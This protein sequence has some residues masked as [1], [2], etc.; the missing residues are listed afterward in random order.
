MRK[1]ILLL[2][3]FSLVCCLSLSILSLNVHAAPRFDLNENDELKQLRLFHI[4]LKDEKT[5]KTYSEQLRSLPEGI[6]FQ[7]FKE[8]AKVFSMDPGSA[9]SGGD[10]AWV[11]AG[12]FDEKFEA[13][14]F[15]LPLHEV[16][17]PVKSKFGWHIL[18]V[19]AL[20]SEP[21]A[22]L[23]QASLDRYAK[24]S[25][26]TLQKEIQFNREYQVDETHHAKIAPKLGADWSEPMRDGKVQLMYLK[27]L[28][29]LNADGH[30]RLLEHT[31][32]EF[33][34]FIQKT[35]EAPTCARSTRKEIQ[36]D[37][38]LKTAFITGYKEYELRGA[39]GHVVN[40]N[41][42]KPALKWNEDSGNTYYLN[43]L[44]RA[45]CVTNG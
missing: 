45:A 37:C 8:L 24:R 41:E 30:V 22:P 11:R 33:A 21:I 12:L 34:R 5:A 25:D 38:K 16:S 39:V 17:A 3:L 31:E 6:R 2:Q 27:R 15:A 32:Y 9:A 36:M 29:G 7:R 19:E 1:M 40:S 28:P 23:C 14:V 26:T 10:L 20:K 13:A 43:R 18:Y 44:Y 4:M 42:F 35:E